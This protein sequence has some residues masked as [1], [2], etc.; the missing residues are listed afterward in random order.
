MSE[1]DNWIK[2]IDR[3]GFTGWLSFYESSLGQPVSNRDLF[4]W[5][6]DTYG[7][8]PLMEAIL[9]TTKRRLKD[10]PLNYVI[11]VA[12][13]KW[14]E[15]YIDNSDSEKYQRGIERGKQ[16]TAIRNEELEHK[17]ERAK[18]A[19]SNGVSEPKE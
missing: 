19:I 14:K 4:Q 3:T 12:Q 16:V 5:A 9:A 8:W 15:S 6:L 2:V 10:D 17:L 7:R 18:R 13:I 1:L 11:G